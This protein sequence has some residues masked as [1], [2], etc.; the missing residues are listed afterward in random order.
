MADAIADPSINPELFEENWVGALQREK[1]IG[2]SKMSGRTED[3]IEGG[4]EENS[5]DK[6]E[7]DNEDKEEED[8][9]DKEEESG[10]EE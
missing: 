6:E 7:E 1:E 4:E 8:S 5:E 9:E 2:M 3:E 10:E